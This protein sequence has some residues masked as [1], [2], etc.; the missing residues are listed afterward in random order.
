MSLGKGLG[1]TS[2]VSRPGGGRSNGGEL[3]ELCVDNLQTYR[4]SAS[5]I[6]VEVLGGDMCLGRRRKEVAHAAGAKQ[7]SG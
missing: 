3:L 2:M 6:R 1:R 4:R 7:K 5:E